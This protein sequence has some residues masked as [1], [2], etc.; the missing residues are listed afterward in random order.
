MNQKSSDNVGNNRSGKSGR[1]VFFPVIITLLIVIIVGGCRRSGLWLLKE[2][3][4]MHADAMV[5]LMGSFPERVLQAVD[6]YKEG[7][8]DRI[9]MVEE[10]MGPFRQLED[11]GVEIVSNSEQAVTSLATLGVPADSII[12]L[13]GDAR[14]TLDEAGAVG[15]YISVSHETDTL[16]LVSS[17]AHTRRAWMIFNKALGTR[18]NA[19][20]I[21]VSPS[22]YSGFNP[23]RWWRRKEDIQTVITEYLKIAS[24]ILFES[25]G[26]KESTNHQ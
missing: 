7:K 4:P 26:I 1:R 24:F 10:Y 21:G 14:S 9:I 17:S 6:L 16:L 19:L 15:R 18:H 3:V 8:A 11:R 20:C 13:P 5:V 2:N 23:D 22:K 12:L 25:K